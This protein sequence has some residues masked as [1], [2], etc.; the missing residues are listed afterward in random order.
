MLGEHHANAF[1]RQP[2]GLAELAQAQTRGGRGR[3]ST[4]RSAVCALFGGR[5]ASAHA[6]EVG[7]RAA[8]VFRR[9]M[10]TAVRPAARRWRRSRS[11]RRA[12]VAPACRTRG[13][14]ISRAS[15]SCGRRGSMKPGI[16]A[17]PRHP[18]ERFLTHGHHLLQRFR[19]VRVA[20]RDRDDV[21]QDQRRADRAMHPPDP[22]ASASSELSGRHLGR[23]DGEVRELVG[24]AQ[25]QAL[26]AAGRA[27]RRSARTRRRW[28]RRRVARLPASVVAA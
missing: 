8:R 20:T 25:S 23:V 6:R 26:P 1:V 24:G 16:D 28:S 21:E 4:S 12:R 7:V 2:G 9:R 15:S 19:G 22:C 17:G 3:P 14:L 5:R 11:A 13:A 18:F 10:Q 27:C